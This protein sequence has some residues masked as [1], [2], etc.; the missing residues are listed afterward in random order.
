MEEKKSMPTLNSA[1]DF[2]LVQ[3][4]MK[5]ADDRE[6]TFWEAKDWDLSIK[7]EQKVELPAK[8]LACRAV[9]REIVFFSKNMIENFAI[10]QRMSM[11]GQVVEQLEF[12]FG[13]VIPNS[14]NSWDQVI[15]ADQENILPAQVL[16]GNLVV[17]TLF[18]SGEK[19]LA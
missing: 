3:M 16:S 9:S 10:V 8:M 6:T 19:V 13:F 18:M 7:D 2:K 15:E 12:K 4:V 14:T 1:E 17:D 11:Q 5:D